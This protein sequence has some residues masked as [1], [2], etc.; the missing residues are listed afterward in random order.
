VIKGLPTLLASDANN[1]SKKG[2]EV[3]KK[4]LSIALILSVIMIMALSV[5]VFAAD[6]TEVDVS[7]SGTG[8]VGGTVTAGDDAVATWGSAGNGNAG[9]F[10]A[11]DDNG[12][13]YGYGVDSCVF[14]LDIALTGGGTAFLDVLRTDAKTSYGSPGQISRTYVWTD[15]GDATLRNRSTTNYAS[16]RDCNY[17]WNSNDHI[18]VTGSSY[19]ELE[20]YMSSGATNFVG[21]MATGAGDADLDCMNAEASEGRVRLGK[22]CGCYTNAH[23]NASGAGVFDLLAEAD[24]EV[25]SAL[26]PGVTGMTSFNFVAT[27]VSSISIPDYSTT[28]D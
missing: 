25:T 17:G 3:M 26:A 14:S 12:N 1:K 27:W 22:G 15:D 16:M 8:V 23:F 6:P 5:P 2:E 9:V 4:I 11:L 19:Y 20:R 24:N 13:P 28:A 18:T 10:Y 7:W 21:L